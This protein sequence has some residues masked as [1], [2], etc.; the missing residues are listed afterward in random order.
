MTAAKNEVS[1]STNAPV[2][3]ASK[4]E[5]SKSLSEETMCFS[6]VISVGGVKAIV[7]SNRGN[8]EGDRHDVYHKE[9]RSPTDAEYQAFKNAM[10]T[11]EAYA[12]SL[13]PE[14]VTLGDHSFDHQPTAES[15]INDAVR[16]VLDR[17]EMRRL[18]KKSVVLLHEGELVTTT[19]KPEDYRGP[20]KERYAKALNEKWPGSRILND[21]DEAEALDLFVEALTEVRPREDGRPKASD[22]RDG[23]TGHPQTRQK[24]HI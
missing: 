5:Y 3:E 10:E 18:F 2:I 4:V 16:K 8:G 24:P 1:R 6:A 17:K 15:L 22:A 12:A 23:A 20:H 21:L 14:K 7:A 19:L 11:L 9:G 13:P